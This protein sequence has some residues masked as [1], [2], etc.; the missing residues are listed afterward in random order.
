[1][2][3]FYATTMRTQI[4]TQFQYRA[5][6]YMYTLGMVAEPTI[7][8]VVWTTIAR[9]HGGTVA[10]HRR[11]RSSRRTTSSGRSCGR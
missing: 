8:L 10:G 1:M 4:Q 11:R 2:F 5:A 3:D 6:T 9:S 7:Y